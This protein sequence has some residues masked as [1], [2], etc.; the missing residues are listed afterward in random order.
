MGTYEP[1]ALEGRK[2]LN[3][4]VLQAV[5]RLAPRNFD[6]FAQR[7]SHK[8]FA[9]REMQMQAKERWDRAANPTD[10]I[11]GAAQP[12]APRPL[13]TQDKSRLEILRLMHQKMSAGSSQASG[14]STSDNAPR[15][16]PGISQGGPDQQVSNL[17]KLIEKLQ[18]KL[19]AA[20]PSD[21]FILF[22]TSA[23]PSFTPSFIVTAPADPSPPPSPPSFAHSLEDMDPIDPSLA[24]QPDNKSSTTAESKSGGGVAL[25]QEDNARTTSPSSVRSDETIIYR[26]PTTVPPARINT[27]S[28]EIEAS[29][30]KSCVIAP[31]IV[32]VTR[33]LQ[34]DSPHLTPAYRPP[35]KKDGVET[36]SNEEPASFRDFDETFVPYRHEDAYH[37]DRLVF[38][39][40]V[41]VLDWWAD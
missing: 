38:R 20:T 4:D 22:P 16:I 21:E 8:T 9:N 37:H 12:A 35:P 18:R 34:V 17:T 25:M 11:N 2:K 26:G 29:V 6:I 32:L 7:L 39:R 14:P 10:P 5:R 36:E 31:V 19:E 33:T 41:D 30:I 27:P 28:I 40:W 13:P 24:L 1:I 23:R 15:P 3:R